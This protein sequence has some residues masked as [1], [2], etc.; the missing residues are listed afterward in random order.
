M[1]Y[2]HW[3]PSRTFKS[4]CDTKWSQSS[5]DRSW[6]LFHG[7]DFSCYGQEVWK[8]NLFRWFE[9]AWSWCNALYVWEWWKIWLCDQRSWHKEA[10]WIWYNNLLCIECQEFVAWWLWFVFVSKWCCSALWWCFFGIYSYCWAVSLSWFVCIFSQHTSFVTSWCSTWKMERK[11]HIE[12]EVRGILV[13]RW[14][15]QVLR[16]KRRSG[17]VVH[18]TKCWKQEKIDSLGIYGP[19]TTSSLHGMHQQSVQGRKSWNIS[20]L[21]TSRGSWCE[22]NSRSIIKLT[23]RWGIWCWSWTY[24]NEQSGDPGGEDHIRKCLAPL[25]GRSAF[26]TNKWWQE[27]RKPAL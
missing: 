23:T 22:C 20:R 19:S 9:K 17:G 8:I 18:A 24:H 11:Y 15:I 2:L 5:I 21:S 16:C 13:S 4:D 7:M 14:D 1:G 3:L 25:A 27:G 26:T 6:M 10:S 12:K